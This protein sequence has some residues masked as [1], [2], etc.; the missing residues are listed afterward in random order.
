MKSSITVLV[1]FASF[2]LASFACTNEED[3][4]SHSG[5]SGGQNAPASLVAACGEW[6]DAS[7][8]R[9]QR[10]SSAADDFVTDDFDAYCARILNAPGTQIDLQRLATCA[11]K[12]RGLACDVSTETVK[13]CD[14]L[15]DAKGTLPNGAPCGTGL[16]CQSGSCARA[17]VGPGVMKCGTCQS[18][19]AVGESCAELRC[20]AEAMCSQSGDAT[21]ICKAAVPVGTACSTSEFCER[22]AYCDTAGTHTCRTNPRENEICTR[23]TGAVSCAGEL[24]CIGGVCRPARALGETCANDSECDRYLACSTTTQ[25]CVSARVGL[26]ATCGVAPKASC[27]RGLTCFENK[28]V[29]PLAPGAA[30]REGGIDCAPF[31][32]CGPSVTCEPIDPSVCK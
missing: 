8:A 9:G 3:L 19:A 14:V 6:R 27:D 31:Y 10:C 4:G 15:R 18:P 2:V 22:G 26:G 29:Q 12:T 30:C 20:S 5:S 16:Q 32:Y 23:T 24:N 7:I 1:T 11:E 28:C 25:K 17:T 21:P 13:E